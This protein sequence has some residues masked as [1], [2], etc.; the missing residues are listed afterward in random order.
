LFISLEG[1]DGSGKTTQ[2]HRLVEA[3]RARGCDVLALREPGGTAIG[4]QVRDILHDHKHAEMD[5]R[6]E[7]LL[8]CA[9]RA[10]L[11]AQ[12][13][14]PHLQSGGVVVCDRFADTTLA[15]QGYGR[16]LE[17]SLLRILLSFATHGEKPDMTLY[18]EVPV[19]ISLARRAKGE[20]FNRM[21]AQSIE[22]Y[23]RAAQGY[24]ELVLAEPERWC[25]VDATQSIDVVTENMLQM[26]F[27]K[28]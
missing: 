23:R 18:F 2:F 26:V 15:Y 11:I 16:G 10:Q 22:F 4:E 7:L 9:S 14:Q 1:L 19:E 28:L 8:Y 13:I 21:D 25:V 12:R 6:A 20:E 3:L 24:R 27:S 5:A 17:M